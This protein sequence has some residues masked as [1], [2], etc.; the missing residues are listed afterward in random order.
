MNRKLVCLLLISVLIFSGIT[1]SLAMQIFVKTL[2]GKTITLEVEPSD[3]IE[4]VKQKIQD[5]EGIPPDQQKLFFSGK[6]LE[7]GRTLADY[8]IQKESTLHLI[9]LVFTSS[10]VV[11]KTT[12]PTSSSRFTFSD[13]ATATGSFSLADGEFIALDASPG[14]YIIIEDSLNDWDLTNISAAGNASWRFGS[15]SS[16]VHDAFEAG[17]TGVQVTLGESQYSWI[18]FSNAQLCT[19]SGRVWDDQNGDGLPDAGEPVLPG[20]PVELQDASGSSLTPPATASTDGNGNY[21]FSTLP[22]SFSVKFTLPSGKVFSPK[23][24]GGDDTKDSD[25]DLTTGRTNVITVAAGQNSL[26]WDAGLFQPSISGT[27]FWDRNGNRVKD[28]A[29]AGLSGRTVRLLQG[30]TEVAFNSTASDGSYSFPALVPGQSY[31]IKADLQGGWV[32]TL[33]A[34]G[35]SYSVPAISTAVTGKNFGF[36]KTTI[37]VDKVPGVGDYTAIQAAA[38]DAIDSD[39]IRV[40]SGTYNEGVIIRKNSLNIIGEGKP[41]VRSAYAIILRSSNCR[42]E[43]FTFTGSTYGVYFDLGKNSNTIAGNTISG[44]TNGIFVYGSGDHRITNNIIS[45]S[46][47]GLY[48][49]AGTAN[50]GNTITGNTITS[51]GCGLFIFGKNN[52]ITGNTI[53]G[54]TQ[55][56]YIYT[57]SSANNIYS[58][59]INGLGLSLVSGDVFA[60]SS[61]E[62]DYNGRH[63]A[64]RPKGNYWSV[65]Q[66]VDADMDGIGDSSYSLGSE[67]DP[68][69]I[70]HTFVGWAFQDLNGDGIRDSGEPGLGGMTVALSNGQTNATSSA[71]GTVGGYSFQNLAPGSYT[72]SMTVPAGFFATTPVSFTANIDCTG[73]KENSFGFQPHLSISGNK[74]TDK[75]AAVS[76]WKINLTGTTTGGSAVLNNTT[77]GSDGGYNFT[78]LLPGSYTVSEESKPG[79]E[80]VGAASQTFDLFASRSEVNFINRLAALLSG[81]KF[82]DKDGNG[83]L[84]V[85]EGGLQGWIIKLQKPDGSV[86]TTTTDA[87]GNYSFPDLPEGSYVLSEVLQDGWLQTAPASGSYSIDLQEAGASALDFA[88]RKNLTAMNVTMTADPTAV[89]QGNLVTLTTTVNGQGDILPESLDAVQTLPWGLKFV[90]ATPPPQSSE[91]QDGT[92]TLSWTG[93]AA[94]SGPLAELAVQAIVQPNASGKLTSSVLVTGSSSQA[95]IVSAQAEASLQVLT[96]NLPVYLNKT[97]DLKEIWEGGYITYTI[98]YTS[99]V[100]ID[101]TGVVI[102]EQ[103]SPELEFIS[104]TPSPDA[105][106]DNVWTIGSLPAHTFGEINVLFRVRDKANL[107][108]ESQS[109]ASGSGYVNN[110]RRLSTETPTAGLQ[111]TVTLSCREFTPVST[112][113]S[114]KLRDSE[115]TSLLQKEHGSGEYR[116]EERAIMETKNRSIRTEGSLQAVYRPTSFALPGEKSIDYDSQ[117]SSL[118]YTRNRATDA[119]TSQEFRRAK[120]LEL[121]RKLLLDKNETSL[122]MEAAVEGQAH[123]GV[124]KK[125]GGAVKPSPIFE[126]SQDYAGTFRFNQSLQDYGSNLRLARNATGLGQAASDQRLKKSQ[127]SFEHGSGSYQQEELASS[128]ESYMAKDLFVSYDPQYGYGKWKSGIWSK[129]PGQSYLGQEIS[130]ADYIR[131]ETKAAGLNDMSTN[132][133]FQGKARLRAISQQGNRSQ[134]ELDEEYVG[135]YAITRTVHLGGISRFDRPHLTLNKTGRLIDRTTMVDYQITVLNDG[136]AALGPVYVWDIFP[137]G[138]DYLSTSQKPDRLQPGYA[139]WSLLYLRIGQSVNINLRLNVTDPQEELVNVVYASGGHN[140]EWVTAGN[141]SVMQFG[142]LSCCQPEMLVEKQARID[143]ADNSLIWY[144]ILLKN[145]ANVSLVAQVKDRL[146]AGMKILNASAEPQVEGQNLA[147]VTTAIPAGES[148]FIEYLAQATSNGK[149]V[150]TARVEAHAMDGSGGATAAASATVTV[151]E[152]TSYAEDGWRPPEWGLDRSEMICDEGIAGEGA[153]CDTGGC[154]LEGD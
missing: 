64:S 133:S 72:V 114:V 109:S 48:I 87:D 66:G 70:M 18:T 152:E 1:N 148:R 26:H 89:L 149:F 49:Y 134:V 116:S 35:G 103:A 41:E 139:N 106:T 142:W 20:I 97:S 92:T 154:P 131:E 9:R 51:G 85:G 23:D 44:G 32:Q 76:G 63:F 105:G 140:G 80:P 5:K 136:N 117:I 141:M 42:I 146:P 67:S 123:L 11:S 45:G 94:G 88:N 129:S 28:A 56:I 121:E 84:D 47:S 118:T 135:R 27:V 68:A 132:L 98:T 15:G 57:G 125:D 78:D 50:P 25:A 43:G 8:N 120:S 73:S 90:S 17:D 77:T 12:N 86:I 7:D 102:T 93:L 91:N 71:A 61:G 104:A 52:Q 82:E 126:S 55:G 13:N 130:G 143:A 14:T 31:T 99:L 58:N 115:G 59:C 101:L 113:Y 138:T 65:Y 33:P 147:W 81:L 100:D 2:M 39:T 75:G 60:S 111:N 36:H 96:Q 19:I 127:R 83:L 40:H 38:N 53:N 79:W 74:T 69:P 62:Y 107:S 145:Q 110:Y 95:A 144:R 108:F 16:F 153:S 3:S 22:G 37:V 128:A 137:A 54:I 24:Q 124:L 122:S 150:N 29:D 46:D 30:V 34:S 21:S 119:S 112:T 10:L 4:N 6:I 151:G